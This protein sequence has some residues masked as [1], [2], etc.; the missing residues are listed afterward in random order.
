MK[1]FLEIKCLYN[2]IVLKNKKYN[3]FKYDI[4][5]KIQN[6]NVSENTKFVQS[7]NGYDCKSG[8]IFER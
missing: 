7:A 4:N 5:E 6:K 8:N 2:Y 1:F 3:I